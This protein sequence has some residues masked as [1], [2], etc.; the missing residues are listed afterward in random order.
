MKSEQTAQAALAASLLVNLA[1]AATL[2]WVSYNAREST[3]RILAE[4]AEARAHIQ[5]KILA[6]LESGN[7]ETLEALKRT[8]RFN[9]DVDKRTSYRIRT[10]APAE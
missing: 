3:L 2:L 8:L 7:P 9:I 5:E 4:S 6:D 1:F 10:R